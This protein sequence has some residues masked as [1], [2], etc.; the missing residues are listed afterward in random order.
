MVGKYQALA[1]GHGGED[2][3]QGRLLHLVLFGENG[4]HLQGEDKLLD[5]VEDL[6]VLTGSDVLGCPHK[7]L[8]QGGQLRGVG[9]G[10]GQHLLV[11]G[12]QLEDGS[13][14]GQEAG[15]QQLVRLVQHNQADSVRAQDTLTQQLEQK[16]MMIP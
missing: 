7:L 14:V 16:K 2:T 5:A 4:A 12:Q 10:E 15:L 3:Q 11:G 13:G 9:G 6:A 1:V 8:R